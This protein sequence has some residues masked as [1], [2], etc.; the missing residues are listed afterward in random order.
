MKRL[1]LSIIGSLFAFASFGQPRSYVSISGGVG[2]FSIE[3]KADMLNYYSLTPKKPEFSL[4]YSK[5]KKSGWGYQLGL[6]FRSVSLQHYVGFV[7][8]PVSPGTVDTARD[9][10]QYRFILIPAFITFSHDL[11][12]LRL[13]VRAGAYTGWRIYTHE[14]YQF[15]NSPPHTASTGQGFDNRL[16]STL[17][18]QGGIYA[19]YEISPKFSLG[20]AGTLSKDITDLFKGSKILN[21]QGLL[22][23]AGYQ[24]RAA[25]ISLF[26]RLR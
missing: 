3:G 15:N 5:E 11:A 22:G 16:I 18:L 6:T 23:F 2:L 13:G 8:S 9:I 4:Y 14:S 24:G 12:K 26:Y 17:G 21:S 10:R 7:T 19:R 20:I 1:A 25:H